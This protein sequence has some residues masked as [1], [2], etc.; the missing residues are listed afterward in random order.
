MAGLILFLDGIGLA[1][2][3]LAVDLLGFGQGY[4]LGQKQ[5]WGTLTG[6][7]LSVS[8][9]SILLPT[10]RRLPG[11]GPAGAASKEM[12]RLEEVVPTPAPEKG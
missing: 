5:I 10:A 9:L 7:C 2:F 1:A 3:C 12:E 6:V 11:T 4:G 8:G